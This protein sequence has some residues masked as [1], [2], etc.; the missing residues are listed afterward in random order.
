MWRNGILGQIGFRENGIL[1][2]G[3]FGIKWYSESCIFENWSFGEKEF[4]ENGFLGKRNFS[5]KGFGENK[6]WGK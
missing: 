5:D 3:N 4:R 6:Y 1:G 2:I